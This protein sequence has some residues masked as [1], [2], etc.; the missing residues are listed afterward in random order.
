M[1]A[2]GKVYL[3]GAG[4]GNL[5]YLTVQG[6]RLL[7][8]A[9]VLVYDA[10]I[11]PEVLEFLPESCVRFDVGKRGGKPSHSQ[12]EINQLLVDQC[13]LGKQVVRLKS[14][15]PFIFGRCAAEI[16]ALKAA[17]CPFEVTPGL[18][19]ALVAPLL[20]NIPLTDP[21][22]S[23]CFAVFTAH[24]LNQLD[25]DT[26]SRLETL[27]ILM[28]SR[29]LAEIT[30]QLQRHGKRSETPIAIIQWASQPQQQIWQGTLMNIGQ[31][32]KGMR[33]SPSVMVVGEVVR[34]REY[35]GSVEEGEQDIERGHV[36]S[37]RRGDGEDREDREN[38]GGG[39]ETQSNIQHPKSK[40]QLPL[41]GKTVL[42]TRA[43][44]Q[45]SKFTQLLQAEGAEVVETPALEITP[46]SSWE[47]MDGAI[48]KLPTFDWLIL[49]SA[50][51]VNFFLDRLLSQGKD[52]RALADV[53]IAVVGK[54]T[55]Q[56]LKQR[57][58]IPDFIPPNFIADSL[59]EHFPQ[60]DRLAGSQILFPRVESGG[61]EVL[62]KELMAKGAELTETPAYQ[63]A[64]PKAI[65]PAALA[66]LQQRRVDVVIFA[67][68]K[69]VRHFCHL[70]ELAAGTDWRTLLEKVCVASIGPQTSQTCEE[71]LGRV[72]LEAAEFTLEG[73]T[74]A[75]V[76]WGR[77]S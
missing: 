15:D 51:A 69:T 4:P 38:G 33:L 1:D 43:A 44:G 25:W 31:K 56:V 75:I 67:S 61:R 76:Q 9:D 8:Q 58:L 52:I 74:Q 21:V 50:N 19:S 49:T 13:K 48:A 64:C 72:D 60:S 41:S 55:A 62:V 16:Q 32:T 22:L 17:A 70:L 18:S 5:A 14:G 42:I 6:Q 59:V 57:G 37:G 47:L 2:N 28:G 36:A 73:L 71:L 10:L 11:N 34:L 40:I 53:Q 7:A 45:S 12:P 30:H 77:Q 39:G 3:V 65:E 27:V 68:S 66:A 29:S 63:S 35:L 20:A 23:H 54:K 24:D 46:P 26:L